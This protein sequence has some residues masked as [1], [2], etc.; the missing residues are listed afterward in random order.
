MGDKKIKTGFNKAKFYRRLVLIIY[1]IISIVATSYLA[2]LVRY[3]FHISSVPDHFLTPIN[4]FLAINIIITIFIFA[5]FRLYDSLWAFA[6]EMEL[7]NLV[8]SCTI[9]GVVNAIGLQFFKIEKQPVP[10]SYY[11]LYTFLLVI[12]IFVS[13]FSYRF[14]RTQKHKHEKSQD[15]SSVMVI[16]A[17]EAANVI[18]K[19]IVNSLYLTM[20][21]KCIVDDD[22]NKWGRYIQGVRVVGGRDKIK[23]CADLFEIDQIILAIPSAPRKEISK[24]LEICKETNCELKTLPGV[25][26]LVNGD[27]NVSRL[28]NVEIE[29]LLGRDPVTVDIDSILGYVK[30]KVVCVTGGGGSIGS[31]LCRQIAGHSPKQL[32][33]VDI[34]ENNAYDIQ[35]ELKN[36]YPELDLQVLIA[37]VRNTNRVNWIFEHYRPQIVYHAAAHKHV[38][39]ME[40][41]PNEAI[42]N[43]VFGTFKTAMA[44]AQNGCEKFVMISTDKAVNPTNIMGASKRICEMIIQ[45]FNKHYDT[46][47]VAV[48]F[49]NVL[50]SNG[51]VIPLFKKQIAAG[52]PVTVTDPNI[53]RYFMTIP[54]AVSLVL[55]AGAYAKGGEIFVLD[56][57]EPVRIL[58]LAENLIKLSGFKVGEDIKIEFTGLRPGE[59]LYEELLMDEEGLKDTENKMIH[60]GK[61]IDVDES[62]FFEDLEKLNHASKSESSNIRQI[63]QEIVTTYHP[64]INDAE[65]HSAEH[66]RELQRV[67]AKINAT[68]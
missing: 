26:Q 25:Y 12:F 62:R 52:G 39:L 21:V 67:A 7:Q 49:G 34:Y 37:S 53:I 10:Q 14:L 18:I 58:D 38:P 3:D 20:Q 1:D 40:D 57:G 43:N 24:I 6:G 55:Q 4:E 33:I 42:K 35:Q 5:A 2:V 8:V 11:F 19:E 36:K 41:S 29:D 45:T 17:G 47:F 32:I 31:E 66:V 30:G 44:A 68:D 15:V 23:E 16:G 60:I 64:N 51:S 61:P 50:G 59:K 56:M 46:E 65:Q 27:V 13:R 63:V 9:S 28:H 54:E 22:P 48:R